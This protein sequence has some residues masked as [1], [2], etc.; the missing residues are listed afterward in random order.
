MIYP[1]PSPRL[2][3]PQPRTLCPVMGS[4]HAK[5]TF[6]TYILE[7]FPPHWTWASPF[8]SIFLWSLSPL[9]HWKFL[10][11][12]FITWKS[13]Q[14]VSYILL[15]IMES[16]FDLALNTDSAHPLP[17]CAD[18]MFPRFWHNCKM[19]K[20]CLWCPSMCSL[21][22]FSQALTIHPS[23]LLPTKCPLAA[24]SFNSSCSLYFP[25]PKSASPLFLSSLASEICVKKRS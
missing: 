16:I 3:I 21:F 10:P 2:F 13:E 8:T 22:S 23:L 7:W 11:S 25:Y 9:S 5:V 1:H 17:E 14:G 15:Q 4:G 6:P 19:W 24:L 18:F 12:L 20:A